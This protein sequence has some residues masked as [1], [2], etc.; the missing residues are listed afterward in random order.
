M[1]ASMVISQPT[2][3]DLMPGGWHGGLPG[4]ARYDLWVGQ[5]VQLSDG[6]GG[7]SS[8][9]WALLDTPAGSTAALS[10]T[11]I[12]NPTFTPDLPGTY[13]I[14]LRTNGGGPG[15]TQIRVARCL[16][17]SSGVLLNRGLVLPALGEV[18]G[19]SNYYTAPDTVNERDWDH[20]HARWLADYLTVA[21]GAEQFLPISTTAGHVPKADGL[22]GI[23]WAAEAGAMTGVMEKPALVTFVASALQ[24]TTD[25]ASYVRVGTAVLDP[26]ALFGGSGS[27]TRAIKFAACL[28]I[29]PAGGV[30]LTADVRLYNVT[31]GAQVGSA[32]TSTDTTPERKVSGTLAVPADLPNSMQI[33]EVHLKRVGG[34]PGD[35]VTCS[36]AQFEVS[37][38]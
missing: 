6:A 17:D 33:Y 29:Q 1:T 9:E 4:V 30:G 24:P 5:L 12:S 26:S 16:Y 31:A 11:N 38:T 21:D 25:S 15:N 8:W 3:G 22:G 28:E 32:L 14:L 20:L 10:A 35:L 7:N 18:E 19:E 23:T 36:L 37:Y 13:R 2:G 27:V 34:D